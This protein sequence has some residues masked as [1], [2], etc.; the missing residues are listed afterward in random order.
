MVLKTYD[1]NVWSQVQQ[2]YRTKY[3]A[4]VD[5]YGPFVPRSEKQEEPISTPSEPNGRQKLVSESALLD[6]LSDSW[7]GAEQDMSDEQLLEIITKDV[8]RT[9][10]DIDYFQDE[11]VRISLTNILFIYAKLNPDVG[12]KQGM[13]ELAA[14]MLWVL[15]QDSVLEDDYQVFSHKDVEP[16]AFELFSTIMRSA[17]P[18]YMADSQ[19][20]PPIVAKS[21]HIQEDLLKIADL[22]LYN[23]LKSNSIEPQIWGIRWIRLLFGREFTFE[24]MLALW[25]SLFA[26]KVDSTLDGDKEDPLELVDYICLV[27]LLRVRSRLIGAEHTDI[28]TT[29]LNYP[30]DELASGTMY[31]FATNASYLFRNLSPI[32]AKYVYDQYSHLSPAAYSSSMAEDPVPRRP[33]PTRARL[34][35]LMNNAVD[36]AKIYSKTVIDQTQ[37][38]DMDKIV[39]QKFLDVRERARQ[40]LD[41]ALNSKLLLADGSRNEALAA[42]LDVALSAL[43]DL[44][45][46]DAALPAL[47]NI[48]HVQNC[49]RDHTLPVLSEPPTPQPASASS[50]SPS[51]TQADHKA[52]ALGSPVSVAP[53]YNRRK[54]RTTIALS[55]S[56]PPNL[57][58][59]SLST[60]SRRSTLQST[61]SK[62]SDKANGAGATAALESDGTNDSS[63]DSPTTKPIFKSPA[64]ASL[65]QSEFAWMIS[66]V[67]PPPHNKTGFKPRGTSSSSSLSGK[68]A[69]EGGGL[70]SGGVSSKNDL[71]ELS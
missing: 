15:A 61:P 10:P 60:A 46:D 40:G 51:V 27:M 13:H 54:V 47:E 65:V 37:K 1:Q 48:R 41:Q 3:N 7:Y 64:R 57:P 31:S 24:Q 22:E 35:D 62:S 4:L 8:E 16:D 20:Q 71:F 55:P 25:D 44:K 12:Y 67:T 11:K 6:P 2:K 53:V 68:Q 21:A 29:L 59:S 56:P 30:L 58:R 39:R 33:T 26:Y 5:R 32:G 49:L 66:D 36:K 18:W 28:L 52:K 50:S 43:D 34:D 70:E 45:L 17:K 63:T 23:T 38:W 19:S 69:M 42:M 9:F 14:P